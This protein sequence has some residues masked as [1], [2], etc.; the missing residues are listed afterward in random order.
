MFLKVKEAVSL[1][2]DPSRME[3]HLAAM[4]REDLERR[5]GAM[6]DLMGI[7]EAPVPLAVRLTARKKACQASPD[8][9][10]VSLLQGV[11]Y[12]HVCAGWRV[13]VPS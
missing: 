11:P 5:V 7:T 2:E 13:A 1:S 3:K 8:T 6:L 10:V 12:T 9:R 4:K